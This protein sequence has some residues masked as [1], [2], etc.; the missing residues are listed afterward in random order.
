MKKDER[1]YLFLLLFHCGIGFL[2]YL[3][4][5]LSQLYG[6]C[7]FIFGT[8]FII[9]NQNKNNEALLAAAY[10]VGSEVFL[11][12]TGGTPFYDIYKYTVIFFMLIGIFYSSFSK[13]SIPYWIFILLLIPSIILSIFVLNFEADVKKA[14]A[15]NMSGPI[16][17]ALT[18]IYTFHRKISFQEMN[19]ILLF[20]GLPI[21]SCVTYL[22]FYTPDLK[23]ILTSTQ[24]NFETSGGFGPNQVATILGLG[25]FIFVSRI[26]LESKSKL[27]IIVNIFVLINIAYRGII[28]F[29]RGGMITGLVMI[30]FLLII[31]Y[32]KSNGLS[33]FKMIY[34]IVFLTLSMIF[35]WGYSSMQTSGLI[36]KRYANQDAAG[37]EKKSQLSGRD[38]IA[39]SEIEM[40]LTNPILGVGVG[41]GVEIRQKETGIHIQSHNEVT[42]MLAEHGVLGIFGLLI[43]IF[44]P[45]CYFQANK[46][47]L[48]LLPFLIFWFFTINHA[49]MR[50][51]IPAFIYSL[52][53]LNV[54]I[55]SKTKKEIIPQKKPIN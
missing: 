25:I 51:A 43:L 28:T 11:R 52:S 32:S 47:H 46:F 1:N 44:T 39:A 16:C 54:K 23:E 55:E 8:F 41:K 33:R 3:I 34:I 20:I 9:K 10:V 38:E 12:M 19:K 36:D 27:I 22:I 21:V 45:L 29:S 35:T 4:P 6:L 15:F 53:L 49:A 17:L 30:I 26:I 31:L 5:F 7:I 37:R 42:R 40:F 18:S 24:S 2:L 48:F 14:L 13:A 50:T